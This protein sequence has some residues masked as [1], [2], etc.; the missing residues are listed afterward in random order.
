MKNMVKLSMVTFAA[1]SGLLYSSN[2]LASEVTKEGTEVS[3][4]Q[5]EIDVTRQDDTFY[6]KIDVKVSTAIPDDITI[7]QG[8][9]MTMPLP[10]ELELE[11]TY[12]FPVNAP[13]G[14]PVGQATA[15]ATTNTVTTVFNDYFQ[16]K[17][18]NKSISWTMRTQINR[19]VVKDEGTMHLDFKGTVV[20]VKTGS[21]GDT[22]LNEEL[23][24]WGRQDKDDASVVHWVARVNYRKANLKGV[25]VHDTWDSSQEYVPGSMIVNYLHSANPWTLA[26]T[27]DPSFVKIREDGFDAEVGDLDKVVTFEYSTRSKDRSII[28]TNTFTVQAQ[29]YFLQHEVNYKW[30]DGSGEADGKNKPKDKVKP[31]EFEPKKEEKKKTENVVVKPK[32][33]DK[34]NPKEDTPKPPA[35][36]VEKPKAEPKEEPKKPEPKPKETPKPKEEKP[37][38]KPE[39]KETPKPTET[40]KVLPKTGSD[41]H[42]VKILAGLGFGILIGVIAF[43]T[44]GTKSRKKG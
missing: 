21:K 37:T 26:Y 39:V 9:T 34:P 20:D 30:A 38:P 15:N 14:E 1:I 24:K 44:G 6:T 40:K 16:K 2:V 41:D 3:V 42:V 29:D 33:E 18:L 19:E 31:K 22:N 7:N 11:T 32:P 5:P 23:Y 28:P 13:D 27:A 4:K 25:H 35:P 17:P 43:M 10:K 36:E 12:D 8:D